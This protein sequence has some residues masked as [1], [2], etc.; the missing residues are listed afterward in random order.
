MNRPPSL[1]AYLARETWERWRG[2]V[3]VPLARVAAAASLSTAAILVLASFALAAAA[4]QQRIAQFGLDALVVRTPLRRVSD[5]APAYPDLADL[6]RMLTLKLPYAAVELD[7]GGRAALALAGDD[8][9][10]ELAALGVNANRIPV[11]LSASLPPELPVQS[12]L[13]P[14]SVETTTASLPAALRPLGLDEIL[15]ARPGDFP[16]QSTLPGVAATLL[17]RAPAAPPLEAVTAALATVTQANPVAAHA[18]PVVQTALPLL[19]E[20]TALRQAWLRYAALLAAVLAAMIA[21]V[22]GASAILEYE[23]TEFTTALLRSFGVG[24]LTLWL[25]RYAEAAVLAN[26]GG[27]CGLAAAAIAARWALPQLAPHVLAAPVWLPVLGALNVGAIA[28]ALP[29]ATALRRPVGMVL[30]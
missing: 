9:L 30:P 11:L 24:R 8:T 22:F 25:Q 23:T 15:I 20:L 13:G 29:V 27:V 18:T 21:V 12:S 16:M 2:R 19:R 4:L 5:P 28:A 17:V 7:T 1:S 14:W 3:S 10:R 26:A 6:G